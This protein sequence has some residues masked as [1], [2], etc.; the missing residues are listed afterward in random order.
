M[1]AGVKWD[2]SKLISKKCLDTLRCD[3]CHNFLSCGPITTDTKRIHCG[4][5]PRSVHMLIGYDKAARHF[6]FPCRYWCERCDFKH[7][8]NKIAQHE[9]DCSYRSGCSRCCS[10][11]FNVCCRSRR[12]WMSNSSKSLLTLN[13]SLCPNE[14]AIPMAEAATCCL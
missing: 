6:I 11:P 9:E 14:V 10:H 13:L 4:R 8:F 3:N 1:P 12:K 5:C 2:A 7:F